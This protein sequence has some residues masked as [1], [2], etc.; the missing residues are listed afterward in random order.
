MVAKCLS[1]QE[2]GYQVIQSMVRIIPFSPE[3]AVNVSF[4]SL[5]F[6]FSILAGGDGGDIDLKGGEAKGESDSDNG[7]SISLM[8]G[9]SYTGYG[10]SIRISSG[11]STLSSSGSV[12]I[13][14]S[15]VAGEGVSGDLILSTGTS[16]SGHSPSGSISIET[17]NSEGAPAGKIS[18]TSGE[19]SQDDRPGGLIVSNR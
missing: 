8:G 11:S 7:G 9:T 13:Q 15:H 4:D 2:Q 3:F 16:N 19:T 6:G 17:G 12:I 1:L 10:G 18:L 5:I 14:T